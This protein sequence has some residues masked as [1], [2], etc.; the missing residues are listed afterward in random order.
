MFDR[1]LT[2]RSGERVEDWDKV[3]KA[4]KDP[5]QASEYRQDPGKK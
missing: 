2:V 1:K 4:R 3:K 5:L